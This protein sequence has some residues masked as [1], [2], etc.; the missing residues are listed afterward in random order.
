MA[1]VSTTRT[2]HMPV[3]SSSRPPKAT[4]S[5]SVVSPPPRVVT[6]ILVLLRGPQ[7]PGHLVDRGGHQHT[8][9]L[10]ESHAAGIGDIQRPRRAA[11]SHHPAGVL[12]LTTE[13]SPRSAVPARGVGLEARNALQRIR[14]D[15]VLGRRGR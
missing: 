8:R 13:G 4:D 12:Q 6:G 5:P 9:G 15:R 7:Y 11:L 14:C 10:T 1:S 3:I 2:R